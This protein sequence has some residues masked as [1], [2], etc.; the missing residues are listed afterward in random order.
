MAFLKKNW[1]KSATDGAIN[2]VMRIA[3]AGASAFV[4]KKL[5]SDESTNLKKTIKNISSPLLTIT[6]VLG[7]LMLEDEKLKSLCQ[8]MYTFGAL[9]ALAVVAPS[10]GTPLGLSGVTEEE[11]TS[12]VNGVIMNGTGGAS[13][14]EQTTAALPT[15]IAEIE[16][17][18][19]DGKQLS[20]V[21]SYIEQGADDAVKIQGVDAAPTD[22]EIAQSML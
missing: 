18:N 16:N 10:I 3:G 11:I 22:E 8:G 19:Q 13:S 6:A 21:A 5:T 4:L 2:A 7:D 14:N 20:E 12:I 17:V 9:K 1:Q 15:E